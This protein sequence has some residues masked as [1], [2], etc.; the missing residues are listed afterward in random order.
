MKKLIFLFV[1][2]VSALSLSSQTI[3]KADG[4]GDSYELITSK[5]AP[6]GYP[7]EPPDCSHPD[8]GRHIDEIWDS[9]LNE[10]VFRFFI[11]VVPDDDR[12]LYQDRQRNEIKTYSE[13]PDSLK[14]FQG[15]TM[16]FK[17]SFKLD[18]GFQSSTSFTHIHQLKGV[19]G[20]EVKMPLITFTPR[21]GNPDKLQLRYAETTSQIT[22]TAFNIDLLK[23]NWISVTE[24]VTFAEEGQYEVTFVNMV[25]GDTVFHYKN[26]DIRM[27]RTGASFIR[28]KWGVYRSLSHPEHL[29]DEEL[30]FNDFYIKKV[31]VAAVSENRAENK[32][33]FYPNPARDF[34]YLKGTGKNEGGSLSIMDV[35]GKTIQKQVIENPAQVNVSGLKPGIYFVELISG[36]KRFFQKLIKY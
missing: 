27:W 22:L 31:L 12:C 36:D 11:H 2:L 17:W 24:S 15:E 23:G 5:L 29:R 4:P 19:G 30:L 10:Y 16:I 34:I 18:A 35:N 7:L 33:F 20:D 26:D 13:S 9:T 21:K 1:M 14:A 28:P 32:I 25:S 8:F 3:L 6:E